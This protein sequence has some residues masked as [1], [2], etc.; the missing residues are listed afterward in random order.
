VTIYSNLLAGIDEIEQLARNQQLEV[1]KEG[2]QSREAS[3]HSI[4]DEGEEIELLTRIR[5]RSKFVKALS[6][7]LELSL[8]KPLKEVFFEIVFPTPT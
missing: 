6:E 5:V 8:L 2:I 7:K 3:G 4:L 1:L